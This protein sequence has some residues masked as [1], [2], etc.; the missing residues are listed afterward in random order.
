MTVCQNAS[1]TEIFDYLLLF[2]PITF[3]IVQSCFV[4]DS[5]RSK[6]WKF[7]VARA[8]PQADVQ[9]YDSNIVSFSRDKVYRLKNILKNMFITLQRS[10][11]VLETIISMDIP[12]LSWLKR[13]PRYLLHLPGFQNIFHI[14]YHLK[15]FNILYHSKKIKYQCKELAEKFDLVEDVHEISPEDKKT[16][17]IKLEEVLIQSI[18]L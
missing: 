9:M 13:L 12:I 10:K 7:S 11:N 15:K 2:Q 16:I 14:N 1:A 18:I 6:S 17:E 8:L 4:I 3:K 5:K